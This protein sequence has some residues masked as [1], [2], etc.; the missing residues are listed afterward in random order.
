MK[1]TILLLMLFFG[2]ALSAWAQ[3]EAV[4]KIETSGDTVGLDGTLE[5][6]YILQNAAGKKLNPPDFEGFSAGGPSISTRVSMYN[7]VTEQSQTYIYYLK[8]AAVGVFTIKPATMETD[9]G[10]L[11]CEPVKVNVV[12]HYNVAPRNRQ[13]DN[14]QLFNWNNMQQG[15]QNAQKSKKKYETEKI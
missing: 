5:V 1:K 2:V 13:P 3:K 12:E 15:R 14:M 6:K 9:D 11:T 10:A 8:P 4:F 7:G